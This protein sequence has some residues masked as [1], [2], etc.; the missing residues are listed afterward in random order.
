MDTVN[1]LFQLVVAFV[2]QCKATSNPIN[3]GKGQFERDY[4]VD[5]SKPFLQTEQIIETQTAIYAAFFASCT[6]RMRMMVSLKAC[7]K[8][9]S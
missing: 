7:L 4:F 3:H 5:A 6:A 9:S 2:R 8:A 1:M